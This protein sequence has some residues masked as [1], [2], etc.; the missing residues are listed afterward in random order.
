M[1][2]KLNLK[3]VAMGTDTYQ[4]SIIDRTDQ[5]LELIASPPHLITRWAAN[6]HHLMVEEV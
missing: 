1:A 4:R 6:L 5:R 3:P 2:R